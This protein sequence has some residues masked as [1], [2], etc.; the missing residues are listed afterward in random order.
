MLDN[1]DSISNAHASDRYCPVSRNTN[2]R[3]RDTAIDWDEAFMSTR[4]RVVLKIKETVVE[5][6]SMA[7]AGNDEFEVETLAE[8]QTPQPPNMPKC[9]ATMS[10]TEAL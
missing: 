6:N 3:M 2:L 8:S 4:F 7:K 5:P 9:N 1:N 10:A